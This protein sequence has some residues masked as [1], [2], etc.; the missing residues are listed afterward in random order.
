MEEEK[1]YIFPYNWWNGFFD[2]SDANHIGFFE[3]LFLKTKLK[4]F[5]ITY[6]MNKANVLL[7]AGKPSDNVRKYKDWKYKINFIGEPELPEEKNY[8]I[9]LTSVKNIKNVVDLPLCIAYIHC[10]NFFPRI[11]KREEIIKIPDYFCCFI[12]SNPK[13]QIRNKIFEKLNQYKKVNS[14]GGFLNNVGDTIKYPYWSNEYFDLLGN[15]KFIICCENTKI[16]TYSTEKIVNPYLGRTIPIYWGTHNIKNIFNPES[17][18]FLE[19][20]SEESIEKLIQRV[21]EIDNDDIKYLEMVNKNPFNLENINYWNNNY[22]LE[23]IGEKI[24]EL[25]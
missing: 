11:N 14:M 21:I 9:V 6:D 19:D 8:D 24:D 23:K 7:E 2:K 18:I 3:S 15:Y 4:N 5:E 13:C 1:Y 20:E 12:F 25:L 10:N 17:M 22:T 16:A